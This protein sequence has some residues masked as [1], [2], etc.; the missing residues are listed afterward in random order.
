MK[1]W[2]QGRIGKITFP[3]SSILYVKCLRYPIARFYERYNTKTKTPEELL[4][5]VMIRKSTLRYI[6]IIGQEKLSKADLVER[7]IYDGKEKDVLD[8]VELANKIPHRE[9]W[10][11]SEHSSGN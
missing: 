5:E 10:N 7:A 1:T 6:E 3:D 11:G 8:I 9:E 4:F 2:K